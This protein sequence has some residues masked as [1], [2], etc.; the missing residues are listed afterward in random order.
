MAR[1]PSCFEA[2]SEL[3]AGPP[4]LSPPDC[5]LGFKASSVGRPRC[6]SRSRIFHVDHVYLLFPRILAANSLAAPR[7]WR[8]SKIELSSKFERSTPPHQ[9][10]FIYKGL[11]AFC[12]WSE[13]CLVQFLNFR[14]LESVGSPGIVLIISSTWVAGPFRAVDLLTHFLKTPIPTH[15]LEE[16]GYHSQWRGRAF[17]GWASS[18]AATREVA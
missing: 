17:V 16:H 11:S 10:R 14:S 18:K 6:S 1:C 13:W 5:C 9:K 15:P 12:G 2:R 7:K 8:S 4:A 3:K